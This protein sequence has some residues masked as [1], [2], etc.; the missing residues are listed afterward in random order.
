V[1]VARVRKFNPQPSSSSP[2]SFSPCP[3]PLTRA[4]R[5][6]GARREARGAG[7]EKK[8]KVD[9]AVS[10][11]RKKNALKDHRYVPYERR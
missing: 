5:A 9:E 3:A 10:K 8:G 1:Y 6:G 7:Q 4:V 11:R 2:P